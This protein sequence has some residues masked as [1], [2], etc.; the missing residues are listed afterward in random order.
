V[1]DPACDCIYVADQDNDAI[2]KISRG[3]TVSTVVGR[4]DMASRLAASGVA[5]VF[6]Q[7]ANRAA[8]VFEVT[9]EQAAE[10]IRPDIYKPFTVR[11]DSRGNLIMLELGTGSIRRINPLT[12][13]TKRMW[14]TWQ[15]FGPYV[16]GWAWLDVDRWGNSGPRDGIYY[17]V[18]TSSGI[19]GEP[20]RHPNEVYGWIPPEGG[21]ARSLFAD[22]DPFPDGWGRINQTDPPHY[23][24]LIAVDPRGA[25]LIAGSGEHGISRL[26]AR[27]STDP[28]PS[29]Y[30]DYLAGE[31]LW[32]TGGASGVSFAF[33]FGW[34]AHNY[35]GYADA[36]AQKN[37][38]DAQLIQ[39]FEIPPAVQNDPNQLAL[40]LYFIRL[41]TGASTPPSAP[42]NLR[43]MR[44]P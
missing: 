32:M 20:D 44:S 41:N 16:R 42:T 1:F 31:D 29:N 28:V 37:A 14:D 35:L 18:F 3:G 15:A 30:F 38:T 10:G 8:S 2:R 4:P 25:V 21:S 24:W 36:W 26:R 40:L 9:P 19:E 33:K 6:N 23:P 22:W 13:E 27:R 7:Q 39:A 12:G 17:G 34:G 5:D 43:I 11:V